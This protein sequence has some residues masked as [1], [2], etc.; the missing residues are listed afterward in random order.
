M[1]NLNLK[2][3]KTSYGHPIVLFRSGN[4]NKLAYVTKRKDVDTLI[5]HSFISHFSKV[6]SGKTNLYKSQREIPVVDIVAEWRNFPSLST[7][8][9]MAA[10]GNELYKAND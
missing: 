10:K 2:D 9:K 4:G 3:L 6:Y 8:E 7:M 1:K 5:G